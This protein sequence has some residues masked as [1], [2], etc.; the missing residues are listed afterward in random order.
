MRVPARSMVSAVPPDASP[1]PGV[2]G[3]R[4]GDFS[5]SPLIAAL[6]LLAIRTLLIGRFPPQNATYSCKCGQKERVNMA[7]SQRVRVEDKGS[8]PTEHNFRAP[9][10]S[11]KSCQPSERLEAM[12]WST[13]QRTTGQGGW[14]SGTI[15]Q[16]VPRLCGKSFGCGDIIGATPGFA[17]ILRDARRTLNAA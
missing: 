3:A 15:P 5:S 9:R 16:R 8:S 12:A 14:G 11:R 7:C 6:P 17:G 10:Q 1:R 2:L 13:A 4:A